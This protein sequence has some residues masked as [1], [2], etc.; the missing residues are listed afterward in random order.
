MKDRFKI[1][2]IVIKSKAS[3]NLLQLKTEILILKSKTN[4][5]SI[6]QVIDLRR[7]K[8]IKTQVLTKDLAKHKTLVIPKNTKSESLFLKKMM[9]MMKKVALYLCLL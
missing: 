7:T 9:M 5:L 8:I 3:S 6:D 4:L 2:A 1:A